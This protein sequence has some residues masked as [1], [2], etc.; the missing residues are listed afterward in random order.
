MVDEDVIN[1]FKETIKEGVGIGQ[2][3][4]FEESNKAIIFESVKSE[5]LMKWLDFAS[6]SIRV[7]KE[8]N[9]ETLDR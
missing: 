4:L 3:L 5:H 2:N 7:L 6:K 1:E 8:M 9:Q